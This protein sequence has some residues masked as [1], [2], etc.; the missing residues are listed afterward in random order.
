MRIVLFAT[1]ICLL[2]FVAGLPSL[3]ASGA[4]LPSQINWRWIGTKTNPALACPSPG[5]SWVSAAT[6]FTPTP[7]KL[8][9]YCTYTLNAARPVTPADLATLKQLVPGQLDELAAD[10][11]SIGSLAPPS[12]LPK[13]LWHPLTKHFLEQAGAADLPEISGTQR[14]RMAVLDTQP[15]A[16]TNPHHLPANSPHGYTLLNMAHR[17]LCEHQDPTMTDCVVQ[18]TSQLALS[19]VSYAP[20][21]PSASIQDL[22]MG[23]YVGSL[24]DLAKAIHTEVDA[25]RAAALPGQNLVINMS[26]GWNPE[27]GGLEADPQ[28]MPMPVRLVYDAIV[29][30]RCRGAL[31][32]AAAGNRTGGPDSGTGPMMPAAWAV[33]SVPWAGACGL[34]PSKTNFSGPLNQPLL[35]AVG[36]VESDGEPLVNSRAYSV[37]ERVAFGDHAVVV[38]H[39]DDAPTALLTGSSVATLVASAAAAAAWYYAPDIPGEQLMALIDNAGD[40]LPLE[41]DFCYSPNTTCPAARRISVCPSVAA[42]CSQQPYACSVAACPAWNLAPPDLNQNLAELDPDFELALTTINQPT[43]DTAFC[44]PSVS[45]YDPANG[46][47]DDPCPDRQYISVQSTPWVHPQPSSHA[48]PPCRVHLETQRLI[49]EIDPAFAG[50]LSQPTLDICGSSY[51]LGSIPL[52]PGEITV[53]ND[54]D[55][56][57]CQNTTVSFTVTENGNVSSSIDSALIVD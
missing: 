1:R 15:T 25:W 36:G 4:T 39:T 20:N 11:M 57:G 21:D 44:D 28:D 55:T 23:G 47:A 53:V 22:V 54:I 13:S 29:D 38:A 51:S 48:C 5:G 27:F 49:I 17:A 16:D 41:A 2:S 52:E 35:Y 37:P 50:M 9:S 56:Q 8:A 18:L 40:A 31:V 33:R 46:P 12:G 3:E 42:V 19:Y 45:Y 7:G 30:A 32:I 14:V 10:L 24:L 43:P 34:S 26:V 6:F